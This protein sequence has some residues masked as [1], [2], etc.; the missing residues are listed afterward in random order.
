[1]ICLTASMAV[2][3]T[4]LPPAI[5]AVHRTRPSCAVLL[6]GAGIPESMALAGHVATCARVSGAVETADALLQR[7]RLN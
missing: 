1:M 2:S 7:A 3:A 5:A 6:G 4:L